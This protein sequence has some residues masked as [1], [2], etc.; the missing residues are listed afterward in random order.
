MT[1]LLAILCSV[2]LGAVFSQQPVINAAVA[3]AVG[4]PIVAAAFSVFITLCVLLVLVPFSPGN[5]KPQMIPGLAWWSVLGGLIGVVL[6]AGGAYFAPILG[7]AL[8]FV[9]LVAGQLIGSAVA[10][11]IG[12]FGLPVRS[13]TPGRLFGLAM[14]F[15]GALLVHRG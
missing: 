1:S 8:F 15:I 4:S 7:A 9:C 12:A 14:V 6:V 11:H 3:K 2:F 13:L 5:L 10:D